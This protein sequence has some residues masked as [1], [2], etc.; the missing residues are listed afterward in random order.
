MSGARDAP[1][2]PRRFTGETLVSLTLFDDVRAKTKSVVTCCASDLADKIKKSSAGT[3][4]ELPL[5]KFAQFREKRSTRGSYRSDC[6]VT[7]INGIE[8]EYDDGAIGFDAV[9]LVLRQAR[10]GAIVYTSPS[11]TPDKPRYR[12]ASGS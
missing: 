2:A 9:V 8:V 12:L 10:L 5:L 4:A 3:K 6:N 7:A 1:V 11:H